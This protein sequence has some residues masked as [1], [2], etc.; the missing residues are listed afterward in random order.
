MH[1]NVPHISILRALFY[2][3]RLYSILAHNIY[4]SYRF[5]GTLIKYIWQCARAR[6]AV[7]TEQI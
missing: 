2:Y 3:Q 5:C 6:S 1:A 4:R 7:R